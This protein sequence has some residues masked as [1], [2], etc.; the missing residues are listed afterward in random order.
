[1]WA[2]RLAQV[3]NP[4]VTPEEAFVS[5][6]LHDVGKIV[7]C[8]QLSNQYQEVVQQAEQTRVPL[9]QAERDCLGY[10]HADV[11]QW[12]FL[13]WKIPAMYCNTA[14]HHHHPVRN[15]FEN[16][17]HF[18]LCRLVYL[19]DHLSYCFKTGS[20]G[21][22]GPH[23]LS[24]RLLR[25]F[26]VSR[27]VIEETRQDTENDL[28]ELLRR[29][30]WAEV[31][32][33]DFFPVLMNANSALGEIQLDREDQHQNLIQKKKELAG[34]N[35]LGLRLQGCCSL[36]EGLCLLSEAM[37]SSFPFGEAICTLYLNS[38]WELFCQAKRRGPASPCQTLLV[39][40]HR[41]PEPY[42]ARDSEG[43]LLFVDL[44]GKEKPLGYLKVKP[45]PE[46]PGA[47][48]KTGLLLASCAKLASEAI[49]RIQSHQQIQRLS[50]NLKRFIAQIDEERAR[51]EQEKA[52]KESIF[53]NIPLGLLLLDQHGL[54]QYFNPAAKKIFPTLAPQSNRPLGEFFLDPAVPKGIEQV[55]EKGEVFGGETSITENE[56]GV[57]RTYRW[58]LA[59]AGKE[60]EGGTSFLI[61]IMEDVTEQRVLQQGFL[62]SARMA[63]IGELAAGTAHNLRSPLGAVK[64]IM[65]LLLEEMTSGGIISYTTDTDPPQPTN[66]VVKQLQMAIKGLHKCFSTLD[67]L[68]QFARRPD[69]PPEML[70]LSGLLQ[71][72]EA[73]L[74][75][76]FRDRG[77]SI[78][79]DLQA[80]QVFGRKTD[81]MQVFLNI[82][83]NAYKAMPQ[84]G[85]MTIRSRPIHNS[86]DMIPS[87]DIRIS[88]TGCG[89]PQDQIDRIF[90]P[91][92]STSE[93]VEGTGLGLSLTWKIVKEHGG[94]LRVS[95]K[96]G[97]GTV[98]FLS[99][100][101]SPNAVSIS[102]QEP[103]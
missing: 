102:S 6:L 91:F 84:G 5:G 54:V 20:G 45:D 8:T 48:D 79:K 10:D 82:Y 57:A 94:N 89:I 78:E 12:L 14:F 1:V 26:A 40:Q 23:K 29:V 86:T 61:C 64:G 73:L 42:E 3:L 96:V 2:R 39:K 103:D 28:K 75:G 32:L 51:V 87:V 92:F 13:H 98:F 31:S 63:S 17:Y 59:Q 33:S 35:D 44:M 4:P 11:G 76:V 47:M 101:A 99:L 22:P 36:E 19:A 83:S 88:D 9:A 77:I 50:Q 93:R 43:P 58:D 25:D 74:E 24:T 71:G 60:P 53:S 81:L 72:S 70:S 62:E 69:P 30:D 16:P 34:I 38:T 18:S 85:R 21:N 55:L 15:S 46:K 7:L 95:S 100:P 49:E 66:S 52:E 41:S 56:T 68:H 67:D 37:V 27:E 97:E 65:E 80:D 90:D